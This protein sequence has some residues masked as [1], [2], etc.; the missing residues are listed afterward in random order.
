MG[1]LLIIDAPD[2]STI[3]VNTIVWSVGNS[4]MFRTGLFDEEIHEGI[5]SVG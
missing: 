5:Q 3:K 1:T 2:D 4:Y